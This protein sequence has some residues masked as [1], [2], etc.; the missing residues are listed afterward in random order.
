MAETADVVVIGG[1][2]MGTSIAM[3]LAQ[4]GV[5]KVVLVEKKYLASGP[6]GKSLANVRPFSPIEETM[7]ILLMSLHIFKNFKEEIGGDPGLVPCGRVRIAPEKDTEALKADAEWEKKMGV[8]LRFLYREELQELVPQLNVEGFGA[9]IYYPDACHLNPLTTVA[10]FAKRARDLG[11]DIREETEVTAIK[12]SSG[13]V[14]SVIT[15]K[16]EI[17]TPV[18]VN[19]AGVWAQQIGRMVGID[20]P[21]TIRREQILSYLRPW[22]FRGLFPIIH[23]LVNEHHYRP[24]GEDILIAVETCSFKRPEALVQDPDH[25]NEEVDEESVRLFIREMPLLLSCMKRG[26]YRGGY[27]GIYDVPPDE[28]P[29]L[30]KVPEVEGFYICC[31]WSGVGFGQSTAVGEIMAELITEDR[32]TLIDWTVFRLSRFKEGK[33]LISVWSAHR[34]G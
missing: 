16:G 20:I 29:I 15:N 5:K 12:V 18:V 23:N 22:N 31:G 7:K 27:S 13:K 2:C 10:A 17:S 34:P 11:A 21:I 8:N 4:R 24:D 6:T 14:K 28:S 25:F 30:G 9:G 32:T 26:S 33:P 19:A 3:R 1:G